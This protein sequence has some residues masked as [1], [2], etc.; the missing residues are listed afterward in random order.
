MVHPAS[1]LCVVLPPRHRLLISRNRPWFRGL[2][3]TYERGDNGN[4]Y[5]RDAEIWYLDG[6]ECDSCYIRY[7]A[8]TG[9]VTFAAI[10]LLPLVD[11]VG[12]NP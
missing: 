12:W 5:C 2:R 10:T 4:T 7:V 8:Y 3:A 9:S 1:Y 11:M 6:T